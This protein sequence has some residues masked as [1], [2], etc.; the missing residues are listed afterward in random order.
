MGH[1]ATVVEDPERGFEVT[2]I[3]DVGVPADDI[4]AV[5]DLGWSLEPG[6]EELVDVRVVFRDSG[7][8]SEGGWLSVDPTVVAQDTLA[9]HDLTVT[10]LPVFLGTADSSCDT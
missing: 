6:G 10:D 4:E 2:H 3:G 5:A 1:D 7:C 8:A 9:S